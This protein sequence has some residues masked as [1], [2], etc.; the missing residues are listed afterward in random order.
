MDATSTALYIE[1]LEKTNQQLSLWYN[2]LG[3]TVSILTALIAILAIGFTVILWRQGSEY[4]NTLR[5]FFDEHRKNADNELRASVE[6][7]R[8]ILNALIYET[9]E[10]L[11]SMSGDTKTELEKYLSELKEMRSSLRVSS[12]TVADIG[13]KYPNLASALQR[14]Y[15]SVTE[16]G[17]GDLL[18]QL[19][20]QVHALLQQ[21]DAL[22]N[23]DDKRDSL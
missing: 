10:K 6:K 17:G 14:D 7:T 22:E 21:I 8:K 20:A 3:V 19:R 11:D 15:D 2:P 16:K 5:S 13:R 23:G 18:T 12:D 1:V 4:R 9:G